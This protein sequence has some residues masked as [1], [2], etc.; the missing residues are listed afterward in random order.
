MLT[1]GGKKQVA[2]LKSYLQN[3]ESLR[4]MEPDS[5]LS[6]AAAD[7]AKDFFPSS[8]DDAPIPDEPAEGES[9]DEATKAR[10]EQALAPKEYTKDE[11]NDLTLKAE[12]A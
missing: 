11:L 10:R 8:G 2:K 12:Q 6:G 9:E 4:P 3:A 1:K 7:L 5:R